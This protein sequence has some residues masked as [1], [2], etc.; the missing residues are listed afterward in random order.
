MIGNATPTRKKHT[1]SEGVADTATM[2]QTDR[3]TEPLDK[4]NNYLIN[5]GHAIRIPTFP[6]GQQSNQPS[7]SFR[8]QP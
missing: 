4:H 2:V 8:E 1:Q 5:H 3:E 6:Y 7:V